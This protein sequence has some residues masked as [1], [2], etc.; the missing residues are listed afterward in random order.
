M[1]RKDDLNYWGLTIIKASERM[2][3]HGDMKRGKQ[4]FRFTQ[5]AIHSLQQFWQIEESTLTAIG[6]T[7]LKDNSC[8]ATLRS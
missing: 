7:E 1:S 5:G 2:L 6:S 8:V 3:T 4:G